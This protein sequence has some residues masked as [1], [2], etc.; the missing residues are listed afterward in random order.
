MRQELEMLL[1]APIIVPAGAVG[2][3]VVHE[4]PV[5]TAVVKEGLRRRSASASLEKGIEVAVEVRPRLQ[6]MLEGLLC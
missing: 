4:L 2:G 6:S 1:D 5:F 3:P